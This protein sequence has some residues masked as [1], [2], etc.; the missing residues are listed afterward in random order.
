MKPGCRPQ[1]YP[2]HLAEEALVLPEGGTGDERFEE[3]A[4][5]AGESDREAPEDPALPIAPA[6]P[7]LATVGAS[8]P[9]TRPE[10]QSV[11]LEGGLG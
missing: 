4:D 11:V 6:A 2:I 7:T 3:T 5:C 9:E 1:S 10:R 8:L